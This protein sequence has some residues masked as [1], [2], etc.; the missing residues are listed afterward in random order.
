MSV[1]LERRY[2]VLLGPQ[3]E[4]LFDIAAPPTGPM[5][6]LLI[7]AGGEHA[8]LR[9]NAEDDLV[10]DW[11]HPDVRLRLKESKE[12]IVVERAGAGAGGVTEYRVP[13]ALV[14]ALPAP[15][16]AAVS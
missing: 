2:K 14:G 5:A 8:L 7:Y 16:L 9:R 3:G 13:V 4:V 15:V 12:A 6:P 1:R 10:L 11:L